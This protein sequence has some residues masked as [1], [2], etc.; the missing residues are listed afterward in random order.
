MAALGN[1]YRKLTKE[2]YDRVNENSDRIFSGSFA[3][4]IKVASYAYRKFTKSRFLPV[5]P[6]LKSD[7][8]SG[9][10]SIKANIGE[11]TLLEPPFYF[12]LGNAI[13][14]WPKNNKQI[15]RNCLV[16]YGL[17]EAF[18]ITSN[19]LFPSHQIVPGER[20]VDGPNAYSGLM[21]LLS[22]AEMYLI[23]K[24]FEKKSAE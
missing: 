2:L 4:S 16:A 13:F 12:F 5:L 11:T 9:Y 8:G 3:A 15:V 21:A 20:P 6:T 24:G 23:K 22:M 18:R 14:G 1:L 10:F 17:W 7:I 19:V